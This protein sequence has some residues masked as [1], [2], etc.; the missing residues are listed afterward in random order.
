MLTLARRW[1]QQTGCALD[2]ILQVGDMGAFPDHR[3]LDPATKKFA[4]TDP[5]E[6]GFLPFLTETS[7]SR[8]LLA[9]PDSPPIVFCRG[10]HEDFDYLS[11]F[12]APTALDPWG[13]LWYLPDRCVLDWSMLG[14]RLLDAGACAPTVRIAAFGG[15]A[16]LD[17]PSGRGRTARN[18]RRRALKQQQVCGM[19]PRFDSAD[20]A[21]ALH[22]DIGPIDILLTH[23]GPAH[24]VWRGGSP[25][26]A[27]LALRW[28]PRVH[29][30]GHHHQIVGP[31]GTAQGQ[32]IGFEHLTFL[33]TGMLRPGAWGILEIDDASVRFEW[34]LR[35]SHPWLSEV[36]RFTWRSLDG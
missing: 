6:L 15:A 2:A 21:R 28:R 14:A 9:P 22:Q 31:I 27:Q 36:T 29:L 35:E 13:K 17:V 7:D 19:G 30:F 1:Q 20:L 33:E 16:P 18:A 32:L 23:A 11:R 5:D 26:L 10:N 25:E 8:A 4:R 24:P 34:M 3:R 12:G